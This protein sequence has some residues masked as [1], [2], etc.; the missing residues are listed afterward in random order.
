[1]RAAQESQCVLNG[2][3]GGMLLHR[4]SMGGGSGEGRIRPVE[5]G[6]DYKLV[7]LSGDMCS[8]VS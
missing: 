3:G 4:M 1:M 8:H 6:P 2:R 7:L 5:I